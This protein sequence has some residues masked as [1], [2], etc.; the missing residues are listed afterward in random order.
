MENIT[1]ELLKS[2]LELQKKLPVIKKKTQAF[3]YKYA[4]L[5]VIWAEVKKPITEA[6]FAIIHKILMDG[7]E[8]RVY[9]EHGQLFSFFKFSGEYPNYIKVFSGGREYDKQVNKV[10]E[11]GKEITYGKRYNL[12]AIFNIQLEGEDDDAQGT[13]TP[14]RDRTLQERL[15]LIVNHLIIEK[16][17]KNKAE[18]REWFNNNG[19]EIKNGLTSDL[20]TKMERKIGLIK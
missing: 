1:K 3:N 10:Q 16:K 6:G 2:L 7:V 8:T 14:L 12:V 17:I 11:L 19:F 13:I 18:W 20:L 15:G 4:P 5:E 9:H